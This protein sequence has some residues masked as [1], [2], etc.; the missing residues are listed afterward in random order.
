ML[1]SLSFIKDKSKWGYAFRFGHFEILRVDFE[2][3][4]ITLLGFI[5]SE[6]SDYDATNL[7]HARNDKRDSLSDDRH[8]RRR[9][10]VH[11]KE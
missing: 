6:F 10:V 11:G 2:L 1:D 3:I 7:T 5:P 4:A 9:L 8:A